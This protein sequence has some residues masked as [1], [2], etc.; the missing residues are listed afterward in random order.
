MPRP[1]RLARS[2]SG[3][4]LPPVAWRYLCDLPEPGDEDTQEWAEFVLLNTPMMAH[5]AWAAWKAQ[6][7]VEHA[8]RYPGHRPHLW[9]RHDAP[10]PRRQVGGRPGQPGVLLMGYGIVV[11]YPADPDDPPRFESQAAYLRRHGLLLPGELRRLTA[12]AFEPEIVVVETE[13]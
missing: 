2:R 4:V 13:A 7:V 12:A 6:A 3:H 8:A 1:R 10:E 11:S 5:E 9:W